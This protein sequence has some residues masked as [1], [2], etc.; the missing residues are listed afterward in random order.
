MM[1]LARGALVRLL[2]KY[3]LQDKPELSQVA[4]EHAHMFS[5]KCK[6]KFG[7]LFRSVNRELEIDHIEQ[8]T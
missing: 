3:N 7:Q 6:A 1:G 4:L 2:K 5:K 8:K